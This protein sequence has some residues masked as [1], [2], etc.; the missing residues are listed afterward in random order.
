MAEFIKLE[1]L[2]EL[3]EALSKLPNDIGF[4]TLRS[5]LMAASRPMFLAARANA[6]STGIKNR[7]AGATAAAMGRWTRKEGKNRTTLYLGPK[8]KNKKALGLWNSKHNPEKPATRLNHFHLVEFG[9][10]HGGA[11]PFLRPAF[12]TTKELV[13]RN[14]AGELRKQIDKAAAKYASR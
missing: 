6:Q 9:S 10:V 1:G 3:D 12:D 7:D 8:N 5:G 4:K 11:Q 2:K 13:A 14:F